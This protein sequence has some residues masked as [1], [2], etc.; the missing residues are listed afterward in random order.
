MGSVATT[1]TYR[2]GGR[3]VF[4]GGRGR[5]SLLLARIISQGASTWGSRFSVGAA[6][7]RNPSHVENCLRREIQGPGERLL[8]GKVI[9]GD[10]A[11][12]IK[13]NLTWRKPSDQCV[14]S[15]DDA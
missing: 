8:G 9:M 1:E 5:L 13:S 7:D 12:T 6:I 3:G 15:I 14:I 4:I 10:T 11:S 2:Q